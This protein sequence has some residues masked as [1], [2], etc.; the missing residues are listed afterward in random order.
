MRAVIQRVSEARVTVETEV[1]G[2]IGAGLVVLLG[3]AHQDTAEIAAKLAAKIAALRI[4]SDA[5]GKFNLALRDVGGAILVVSQFTLFGD[6]RKGNR[7]SFID[8]AQPQVAQAL[9]DRFVAELRDAGLTVATGIF[10]AHMQVA[11]TND[12]PV[13][14]IIDSEDW[15][16]PRRQS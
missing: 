12:G 4:F 10:R 2:Q 15:S 8:A 1:V 3:I 16:R 7:P 6:T 14:I 11:L 5:E 13:T 9:V